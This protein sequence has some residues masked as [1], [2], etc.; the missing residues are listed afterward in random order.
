MK[1]QTNMTYYT[2]GCFK[3][4]FPGSSESLSLVHRWH[5]C[6]ELAAAFFV[7]SEHIDHRGPDEIFHRGWAHGL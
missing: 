5:G 3:W 2:G 6:V 4:I 1:Q 7:E